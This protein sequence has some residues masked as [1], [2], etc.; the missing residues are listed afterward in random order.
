[1]TD[2]RNS[3]NM[4]GHHVF[5]IDY[6]SCFLDITYLNVIMNLLPLTIYRLFALILPRFSFRLV[7]HHAISM[8]QV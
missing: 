3:V 1:M 8:E 5:K 6:R 4:S 7:S 2:F